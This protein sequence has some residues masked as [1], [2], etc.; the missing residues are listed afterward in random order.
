[1]VIAN[2]IFFLYMYTLIRTSSDNPDFQ[3]LVNQLDQN[4]AK[5]NGDSNNFFAQHNKIDLIKNVVLAY[6]KK[7]VVGCGAMKS[8][9]ASS[10][11]IK[12]MFVLPQMRGKGIATSI[13]NELE[14]WAKALKY[15][16]CIMETGA[17]MPEAISVYKKNGYSVTP[18]YEPY[19]NISDSICF[20]K[21]LDA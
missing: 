5:K 6:D 18:N 19:K 1:M 15:E 16:R 11:E 12:R 7:V 9:D 13:L 14:T 8:Y 10:M 17:K 21:L 3:K 4:L 2:R 20:E